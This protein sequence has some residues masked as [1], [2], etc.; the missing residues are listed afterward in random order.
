MVHR[1]RGRMGAVFSQIECTVMPRQINR[2]YH[3]AHGAAPAKRW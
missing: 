3:V 2:A 1:G